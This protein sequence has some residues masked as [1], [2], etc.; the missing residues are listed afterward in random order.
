[1]DLPGL[2]ETS[3]NVAVARP[4]DGHLLVMCHSRSSIDGSLAAVRRRIRSIAGL[5]GADV[6]QDEAYPGWRP[7]VES[8]LLEV[9]RESYE[10]VTGEAPEVG[11][12][13]AGLE[14]GIIGEKYE[15]MDMVSF[16][17]Q[18]EFPHSPDERVRIDSVAPF[19]EVL[20]ATL[21]SLAS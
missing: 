3:T 5:A 13:H 9:I 7:D 21:E 10:A 12:M 19:H 16:G 4:E 2:V 8:R 1:L 6:S 11:A 18:I 15:D 20:C 14:C 17:P